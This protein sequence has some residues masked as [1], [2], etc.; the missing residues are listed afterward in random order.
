MPAH[1]IFLRGQAGEPMK[2]ERS[3]LVMYSA[4]DMYELVLDVPSYP[5]FLRWCTHAEVHEQ[6]PD[7]QLA[8]L[9]VKVAGIEQQF[10]TRNT[11]LPGQRLSLALEEGPFRRLSGAWQFRNLGEAG[12]KVSLSLEF[13]FFPGLISSAF[14][15]GFNGIADHL[16]AEFVRRANDVLTPRE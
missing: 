9:G 11:L 3:A 8:S 13:D 4:R 1:D 2:I 6:T 14:Q 12:S 15:R 7:M 5:Q 16:V 10:R